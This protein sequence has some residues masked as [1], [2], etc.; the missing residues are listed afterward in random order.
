MACVRVKECRHGRFCY[1]PHDIYIGGALDKWGVYSED[2]VE[3][4]GRLL[5]PGMR[6]VEVG[7]NIGAHTV[8]IARMVGEAGRVFAFEP[9]RIIYQ[10]LC[11]NIAMN[12]LFN[13]WTYQAALGN[14]SGIEEM[15]VP[16]IDYSSSGNF[17]G[18]T[19]VD[20]SE[21]S[22]GLRRLDHMGFRPNFLKIDCEGMEREVLEGATGDIAAHRPVIYCENDRADKSAALINTLL[23]FS[24]DLYWHFPHVMPY[25]EGSKVVVVSSN[26]LCI[27]TELKMEVSGLRKVTGP[28]DQG[29]SQ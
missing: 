3:L 23:N 17:G 20:H 14:P 5:K 18:V 19:L 2:E 28:E 25:Q 13:V 1:F 4:F 10:Q 26:M 11:A 6:V 29:L 27:P 7:A 21:E 9:Q 15:G 24:Y 12:G 22:V 16:P 8:P